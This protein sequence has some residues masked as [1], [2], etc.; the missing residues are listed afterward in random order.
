MEQS[1]VIL[2][3]DVNLNDIF[4]SENLLVSDRLYLPIGAHT[5]TY[6]PNEAGG[7]PIKVL[8]RQDGKKLYLLQIDVTVFG[9]TDVVKGECAINSKVAIKELQTNLKEG[10]KTIH[11]RAKHSNTDGECYTSLITA[12]QA[13]IMYKKQGD[14]AQSSNVLTFADLSETDKEK[15]LDTLTRKESKE[16][17]EN[18]NK[19]IPSDFE[20][21][22]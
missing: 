18:P 12:K 21:T 1:N 14:N 2:T 11:V 22:A 16:F 17:E 15:F 4:D 7:L 19:V 20:L 5:A 10:K 8:T 9:T 6:Q 3:A 13:N